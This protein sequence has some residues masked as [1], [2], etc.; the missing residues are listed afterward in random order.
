MSVEDNENAERERQ[1]IE[2]LASLEPGPQ[3]SRIFDEIARLVVLS[4]V[5]AVLLNDTQ[6]LLSQ[7]PESDVWSHQW[8]NPGQVQMPMSP[9]DTTPDLDYTGPVDRIIVDEFGYTVIR[10]SPVVVLG[11]ERR[12]SLR[13]SE[14]TVLAMTDVAVRAG[15]TLPEN[16]QFFDVDEVLARPP[17]LILINGHTEAIERAIASR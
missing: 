9:D 17:G 1:A 14:Q 10:T 11:P 4:T 12:H 5:E 15:A 2:F 3:S 16:A 7:R 6:V 8:H 13:G